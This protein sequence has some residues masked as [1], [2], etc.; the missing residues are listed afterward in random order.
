MSN[1]NLT[2]SKNTKYD[3][4][5]TRRIDVENELKNY[6]EYNP[7]VFKNKI[8]LL[9]CDNPKLS[10]FTKHF[11]DNFEVYGIKEL[12]STSMDSD[13]GRGLIQRYN[14]SKS[15]IEVHRLNGDGDFRSDELIKLRGICDIIVTNPP[16]SLFREFFNWV[17]PSEKQFI[18]M[19]NINMINYK[20]VFPLIQNRSIWLG[21]SAFNKSI[22][23]K[24]PSNFKYNPNYKGKNILDGD[25]VFKINSIC[26]FT[27]LE[28]NNRYKELELKTMAENIAEGKYKKIREGLA[29]QKYDNYDAIEVPYTA[30]IPKDYKGVMGVPISFLG[31]YNP[32]QFE[33]VWQASGNTKSLAPE[34]ILNRLNYK[35]SKIDRGGVSVLNGKR[36]YTRILIQRWQ[37]K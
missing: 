16:F 12:I 4:Y 7:K 27:N 36:T 32:N 6:L 2:I 11:I 20:D 18:S 22:H 30:A 13:G 19:G 1:A 9:P 33:I 34:S 14:G 17:N 35:P 3:E 8:V 28:H 26:W 15:S 24:V 23:F 31:K 10:E 37:T 29:Y 21:A 5:Y 25:N